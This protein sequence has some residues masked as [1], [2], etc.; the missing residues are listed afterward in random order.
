[1]V[2]PKYSGFAIY[3]F[4]HHA[5][6]EQNIHHALQDYT[7]LFSESTDLQKVVESAYET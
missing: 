6:I 1:M 5:A 7:C 3:V 2:K 4:L